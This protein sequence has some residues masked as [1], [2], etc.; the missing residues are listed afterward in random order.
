MAK[1]KT[2]D[3]PGLNPGQ[4]YADD[5]FNRLD[6]L[7]KTENAGTIVSPGKDRKTSDEKSGIGKVKSDEE[8]PDK[9]WKNKVSGNSPDSSKSGGRFAAVKKK[10][11]LI[12]ILVTLLLGGGVSTFL[13]GG[14]LAPIAFVDNVVGD[15]NDQLSSLDIRSKSMMRNKVPNEERAKSLKGCRTLSIRCK[16]RTMSKTTVKRLKRV[17]IEVIGDETTILGRL[18]VKKIKFWGDE[19]G[20]QE[21][22]AELKVNPGLKNAYHRAMN[23]TYRGF[24]DSNFVTRVLAKFGITRKPPELKGTKEQRVQ[25]LIKKT[26]GE[27]GDI[28]FT[29]ELDPDGKETG[30]YKLEGDKS[31]EPRT[32]SAKEK[33]T[34]E[35]NVKNVQAVHTKPTGLKGTAL[36]ALSIFGYLDLACTV[37]D[38]MGSAAMATKVVNPGKI[39]NFI[40]KI[41]PLVGQMK[42]GKISAENAE[43][44]YDWFSAADNQK[45]ITGIERSSDSKPEEVVVNENTPNPY[46][47]KTAMDS[48]LYRMSTTGEVATDSAVNTPYALGM[49]EGMLVSSVSTIASWT[50]KI[51]NLG[52]NGFVCNVVQSWWGRGLGIIAGFVGGTASAGATAVAQGEMFAIMFAVFTVVSRV[53]NAALDG[54]M[55]DPNMVDSPADKGAVTWTGL[56]V[57][58]GEAAK[59]RGMMPGSAEQ[60]VAYNQLQNETKLEYIAMESEGVNPLD[61]TNKYSFLGRLVGTVNNYFGSSTVSLASSLRGV[62]SLVSNSL[63]SAINPQ[64]TYAKELDISR[65]QK[66]DDKEYAKN[67]IGADVQCNVR[68]VM[69]AEDLALDTDDVASYMETGGY[70]E[71]DTTTG[72]PVGY[73]MPK[74]SE[75]EG[76]AKDL[77]N[78]IV[79]SF[80]NSRNYGDGK[81]AE[82]GQFLDFCAYRAMPFGETYE[83]E[84]AFGA[85]GSGWIDGSNCS[86]LGPPYSYFRA[87]TLDKTVESAME[88]MDEEAATNPVSGTDPVPSETLAYCSA[89]YGKYISQSDLKAMYG[90]SASEVS[91]APVDFPF[92][93]GIKT[94]QVNTKAA[95]CFKAVAQALATVS[96]RPTTNDGTFNWRSNRNDASSLSFHSFGIAIDLDAA[97]NP[98][99]GGTAGNTPTTCTTNMP[100]DFVD[101]WKKYGFRWGGD[102]RST[103]DAMHF[104]WLGGIP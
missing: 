48:D 19:M 76:F 93:G 78:G 89:N 84:G 77:L 97:Q 2:D 24:S 73:T 87:Y 104:E 15:L 8:N 62:S 53:L 12:A 47:G 67:N 83:E 96:F 85:A 14:L 61:I 37:K 9:G 26:G 98:N 64:A 36:K 60:V 88:D 56:A 100:A 59:S 91:L 27:G 39:A 44:V 43:V 58:S 46:Y 68:Y 101:V 90:S 54:S 42:A 31:A 29:P 35:K 102:Y 23:M 51:L 18:E 66:C 52:S 40:G 65:F 30:K 11:P 92:T 10:S 71:T 69:P 38:M 50:N 86:K 41:L 32:Y 17:G 63:S 79:G 99:G 49:G 22:D 75:S 1:Q 81:G 94:I 5:Q 103:C 34:M 20:P 16:F 25:E 57:I 72:L 80:Y 33:A 28:K 4:T 3:D 55:F 21:F 82:Y 6:A 95:P 7:N 45:T 13:L 74:A 70:V